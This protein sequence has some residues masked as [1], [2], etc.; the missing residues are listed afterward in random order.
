MDTNILLFCCIFFS[1]CLSLPHLVFASRLREWVLVKLTLH[2][3][4]QQRKE[5]S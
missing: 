4:L 1:I 3:I 5:F 2:L